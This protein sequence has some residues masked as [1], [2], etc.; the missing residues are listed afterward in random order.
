M[1]SIINI[2]RRPN[3]GGLACIS[4]VTAYGKAVE[5][6]FTV[7]DKVVHRYHGPGRI[8]RLDHVQAQNETRDCYVVDMGRGLVVWVP[9]DGM[10]EQCL[11]PP[12]T[13]PAI[14]ALAD[15]LRSPAQPLKPISREREQQIKLMMKDGSPQVLCA[16]VRD[17]TAYTSTRVP[18]ANDAAVLERARGILLAEWQIATDHPDAAAEVDALLRESLNRSAQAVNA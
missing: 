9:I 6:A 15:I 7:G 2:R 3:P 10:S 12:L 1:S 16:I 4:R 8:T 14:S 13:A 5:M 11:R 18:T 17:L